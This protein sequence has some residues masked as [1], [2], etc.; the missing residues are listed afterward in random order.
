MSELTSLRL[1][2]PSSCSD[3]SLIEE[4]S[5]PITPVKPSAAHPV[6]VVEEVDEDE[7]KPDKELIF[8][9]QC[10]KKA[11][12]PKMLRLI[13]EKRKEI[14]SE[15]LLE[16]EN[17]AERRG[18]SF[19]LLRELKVAFESVVSSSGLPGVDE[20]EFLE[21]FGEHLCSG[22]SEEETRHWFRCVD[23]NCSGSIQWSEVTQ[24]LIGFNANPRPAPKNYFVDH[25]M[26]PGG[27]LVT[28]RKHSK[29]ISKMI[30]SK[31]S[32][33]Y[34]TASPDGCV[35]CW[36]PTNFKVLQ[37]VHN[38]QVCIE[39]LVFLPH[40]NRLLVLQADRC[41]YLYDCF[42]RENVLCHELN[43]VF[44]TKG[45]T[46][47]TLSDGNSY[48]SPVTKEDLQGDPQTVHFSAISD[49][50]LPNM[51]LCTMLQATKSRY[52][53]VDHL[54][55]G[56]SAGE[57][58][59]VGTDR[60][61]LETLVL[62]GGGSAPLK[63][64]LRITVHKGIVTKVHNAPE[65]S[66]VLSSSTDHT[67]ALTDVEKG[68]IIQRIRLHDHSRPIYSFD[69]HTYHNTLLTWG[70]RELHL[71][72]ALTGAKLSSFTEHDCPIVSAVLNIERMHAYVL[73]E[74]NMI[75]VWD[76]R[77]WKHAGEFYDTT[78]R[79]PNNK[80]S[81]T[82]WSKE[83]HMLVSGCGEL[84]GLRPVDVQE[85][86]DAGL[87]ASNVGYVGHMH[88]IRAS[89]ALVSAGHIVSM[90][91]QNVGVW[92]FTSKQLL[93]LWKWN[94]TTDHITCFDSSKDEVKVLIGTEEGKVGWYNYAC[95]FHMYSLR[96]KKGTVAVNAVLVVSDLA[97]N[98]PEVGIAAVGNALF[99][100]PSN[101]LDNDVK[102][103]TDVFQHS[104]PDALAMCLCIIDS[105]RQFI[106]CG[107]S[108]SEVRILTYTLAPI[109]TL[110][111][112]LPI[113]HM[114]AITKGAFLGTHN[115]G[116]VT[117]F[118]L[119]PR[120][121]DLHALF[122]VH[123]SQV[124][125]EHVTCLS[126]QDT[127]LIVGDN[128]GVV[129]IFDFGPLLDP[130]YLKR[131]ILA[132]LQEKTPIKTIQAAVKGIKLVSAFDVHE[133]AVTG[134][135]I[136]NGEIITSGGDRHLRSWSIATQALVTEYGMHD[137][138][139]QPFYSFNVTAE[140]AFHRKE[141]I[142]KG[143]SKLSKRKITR[144]LS[145]TKRGS[146]LGVELR[147]K[148]MA[149]LQAKQAAKDAQPKK[150]PPTSVTGLGIATT[151]DHLSVSSSSS[152]DSGEDDDDLPDPMSGMQD[153]MSNRAR[154]S[155][156]VFG[157]PES[158]TP[159]AQAKT[160][161]PTKTSLGQHL[162]LTPPP[163]SFSVSE[164]RSLRLPSL[165][166]ECG[167]PVHAAAA[168]GSQ[169]MTRKFSIA[170]N[171]SQSV[172][173]APRTLPPLPMMSY[174]K[175]PEMDLF[176]L[177]TDRIIKIR[178]TLTR[179]IPDVSTHQKLQEVMRIREE[180]LTEQVKSSGIFYRLDMQNVRDFLS[181]VQQSTLPHSQNS[182]KSLFLPSSM[183]AAKFKGAATAS[184]GSGRLSPALPE[185]EDD[186]EDDFS[187]N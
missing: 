40:N 90:D 161:Q 9:L 63:V 56:L 126:I 93:S 146:I 51:V 85:R 144:T 29:P 42:M 181:Q 12:T 2:E 155:S 179:V 26:E 39:D 54:G 125:D 164:P 110:Q 122:S 137:L 37:E 167:T 7:I 101:N 165:V 131:E 24:Y 157:S 186:D 15:P 150:P 112:S 76:I 152:N 174:E 148:R 124:E 55:G 13:E 129:S 64:V 77:T 130:A 121:Y 14:E 78:T 92:G 68:V 16:N 25:T 50:A 149:K 66:G 113:E 134:L 187:D 107:F 10:L 80:L 95:G 69:Y 31:D 128:L 163:P 8:K 61:T 59:V 53:C 44:A 108:N 4:D 104:D 57:P 94:S 100:W 147:K 49:R 116:F 96:H 47:K 98:L 58:V 97:P 168:A 154:Y 142:V 88:P 71:W 169:K 185:D 178:S 118:G 65:L 158:L 35:F 73:T 36:H 99:L 160:P 32:D 34:Y 60:G 17:E 62:I 45:H 135:S 81:L 176:K 109:F 52:T 166:S 11:L 103:P 120:S 138:N 182:S 114:H 127:L 106:A 27:T 136:C 153:F 119:D 48:Y 83:H 102:A 170:L 21:L 141:I 133:G 173:D 74:S 117:L 79:Y 23:K 89:K 70:G 162:G 115:D 123:C 19:K 33:T 177:A 175:P 105:A 5:R 82:Y 3:G 171:M 184:P 172:R 111:V 20:K 140:H 22:M 139:M 75:K 41:I 72:N 18:I 46:T 132:A 1:A 28:R 156:F 30:F 91:L 180:R 159:N 143:Q 84:F 87:R 43:R 145:F 151:E 38:N 6:D 86:I 183:A 67:V